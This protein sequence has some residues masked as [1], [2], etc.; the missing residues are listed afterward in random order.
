MKR[1]DI[2]YFVKVF[3]L[4][5]SEKSNNTEDEHRRSHNCTSNTVHCTA[6]LNLNLL[7]TN[8]PP[9][10]FLLL[11]LLLP[12]FRI[13]S[14]LTSPLSSTSPLCPSMISSGSSLLPLLLLILMPHTRLPNH[15]L[16]LSSIVPF[17]KLDLIK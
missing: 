16:P 6:K 14:S 10:N 7:T 1:L 17:K 4:I 2:L 3:S 5:D 15:H 8:P 12:P 13:I 9:A 11:L